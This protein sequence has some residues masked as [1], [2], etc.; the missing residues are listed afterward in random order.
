MSSVAFKNG[1]VCLI[2]GS[3]EFVHF[4]INNIERWARRKGRC[5][6]PLPK[7]LQRIHRAIEIAILPKALVVEMVGTRTLFDNR[8]RFSRETEWCPTSFMVNGVRA[9]VCRRYWQ[10]IGGYYWNK[11][12]SDF[13]SHDW[14]IGGAL[15]KDTELREWADKLFKHPV[16][17]LIEFESNTSPFNCVYASVNSNP[18]AWPDIK[19]NSKSSHFSFY[20][21]D[22]RDVICGKTRPG[23]H[24]VYY[25]R[26]GL[27]QGKIA[28]YLPE[29]WQLKTRF[30]SK[31]L[32]RHSFWVARNGYQ[33]RRL[34]LEPSII[35]DTIKQFF[36]SK[37]IEKIEKMKQ[38]AIQYLTDP[39]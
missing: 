36:N 11:L 1:S 32:E 4:P 29:Y 25:V 22:H 10:E 13:I 18:T 6:S 31:G 34:F 8:R 26:W 27:W 14:V 12:F 38:Q 19:I 37:K 35:S 9:W 7:E 2:S 39:F 30:E 3:P 5:Y 24:C 23:V 16:G 28:V 17:K 20:E 21:A 33:E 15:I